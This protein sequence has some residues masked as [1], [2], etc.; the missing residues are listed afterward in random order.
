MDYDFCGWATKNNIKCTDGRTIM[1]DAF[2]HCDGKKIPLL[3]NHRH[4]SPSEVLGHAVL[5]NRN[6]GVYAYCKFNNTESGQ[7]AKELVMHDDLTSLSIFANNLK[8]SNHGNVLHGDIHELSL[9]IGGANKGAKIE[10]V[11][12]HG[13]DASAMTDEEL[14]IALENSNEAIITTGES[15]S[16]YHSDDPEDDDDSEEDKEETITDVFDT[17]NDKQKNAVYYVIGK[18]LEKNSDSN[19]DEENDEDDKGGKKDM[20]QIEHNVFDQDQD[21]K[22]N[23]YLS[24]SAQREI[25]EASK[26]GRYG[27]FKEVLNDYLDDNELQHDAISSGFA[28]TGTNGTVDMLFPEYRDVRPGAPELITYDQGWVSALM[29]KIHKSPIS[30][31]RTRQADIRNITALRAKGYK[32]GKEKSLTGN[33]TLVT[34]KTDPQTIYIKNALHRDDIVDI[35]D[36]DYV[37]YLYNIDKIMLYEE[38]AMAIMVGD[39][40]DDGDADKIDPNYIKPI[41]LDDDLYTIHVNLDVTKVK[42]ELQGTDTSKHFGDNYIYSEAMVDVLLHSRENYK[43]SGIP[44]LYCSPQ[45]LNKMLLARDLNGRRI[46]SSRQELATALNVKEIYPVEQFANQTRT[47]DGATK[48]LIG[49]VCNV[50]DYSLGANKGGQVTHF[51]DFDIDFNQEKSL[52]ETRCSG[53]L[54]RVYSAIA[55]E[56]PVTQAAG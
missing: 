38:L 23:T 26:S 39:G 27:T 2:K 43:G 50:A 13:I 36:F 40:R 5:K 51:T 37:Q 19:E 32:K 20:G 47:V 16:L 25:I 21:K 52:I 42:E 6:E 46:Y 1:K 53:A 18:V 10:K 3:W 8:Q 7:T 49:I 11:L 17:L 15:V 9:V 22:N 31:I 35:E 56:E 33:F 30:R 24:H 45:V 34:R 41:W 48:K 14:A 29:A 44:D 4:N 28:Q 54:T 12:A 55:I